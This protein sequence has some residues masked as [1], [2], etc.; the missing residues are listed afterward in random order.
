MPETE[1]KTREARGTRPRRRDSRARMIRSAVV[2]FRERGVDGTSFSDVI[3]HSGAPRGSIYHHFPGGKAQ[4]AEEATRHI[5]DVITAELAR[6]FSGDDPAESIHEMA[7]IWAA[8]LRRSGLDAGC[9]ILAAALEGDRS[10]GARDAAVAMFARSEQICADAF[11]R[12]GMKADRARS[13]AAL[14]VA[15]IEGAVAR[16][17]AQR[18]LEPLERVADQLAE[19][20]QPDASARSSASPSSRERTGS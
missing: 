11:E 16:S 4:L 17:R 19:L 5:G 12:G 14:A 2:L 3:E 10:P 6:V 13:M 9:P 20:V 18:S 7:E 15:A 8:D 1:A